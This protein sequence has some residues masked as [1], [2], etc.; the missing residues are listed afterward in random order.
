M[1]DLE[2]VRPQ[3]PPSLLLELEPAQSCPRF[4]RVLSEQKVP[5]SVEKRFVTV[6]LVGL[7]WF[8]LVVLTSHF[9]GTRGLLWD[10][11]CNFKPR[12]DGRSTPELTHPLLHTSAPHQRK[13]V[14]PLRM[15]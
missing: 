15:I 3:P 9:E 7:V 1:C 11:S 8:S 14:W 4:E 5:Q 2:K 12:S 10:G 13:N 6:L